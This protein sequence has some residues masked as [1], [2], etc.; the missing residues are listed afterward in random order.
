MKSKKFMKLHIRGAAL[1]LFVILLFGTALRAAAQRYES[2]PVLKASQILPRELVSGLN[3]RVEERVIND[4]YQNHYKIYSKFG[5]FSVVSTAKLWKRIREINAI[6]VMDQVKVGKEFLDSFKEGGLKTL[7]G[8]KDLITKPV[9]TV[10]GTIAGVGKVFKS[11][12]QN[13]FGSKRSK[14]EE[15]RLKDV[16]GFSKVKR[17]YAH[18]FS[19]D[20]YSRNRALQDRLDDIT[21]AGYAG[22]LSMSAAMMPI[23][24][25]IGMAISLSRLSRTFNEIFRATPPSDLR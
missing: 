16:I 4:G 10:F 25:G 8:A 14:A 22:G 19:V 11:A 2:S 7:S 6:A 5:E 21:W 23:S 9:R 3:Y 17:D 1:A 18:Q 12:G 24:G 20:V 15:S 13:L